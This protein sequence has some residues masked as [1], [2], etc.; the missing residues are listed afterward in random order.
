[1]PALLSRPP[2][3][4]F[5]IFLSFHVVATADASWHSGVF[6]QGLSRETSPSWLQLSCRGYQ[7]TPGFLCGCRAVQPRWHVSTW[8]GG[9]CVSVFPFIPPAVHYHH[10]ALRNSALCTLIPVTREHMR[11]VQMLISITVPSL[12]M[13]IMGLYY[14]QV[15]RGGADVH[16]GSMGRNTAYMAFAEDM[17]GRL[18]SGSQSSCWGL[19]LVSVPSLHLH[20]IYDAAISIV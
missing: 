11:P 14:T 3:L 2:V 9:W 7:P 13:L 4:S 19:A 17:R 18:A 8:S 1:M 16:A 15:P 20:A 10:L 5:S 6:P 12:R